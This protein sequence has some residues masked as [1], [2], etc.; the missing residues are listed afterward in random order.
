MGP[1]VLQAAVGRCALFPCRYR[2]C[3]AAPPGVR[4]TLRWL[5]DPIFSRPYGDFRGPLLASSDPRSATRGRLVAPPGGAEGDCSMA[6]PAVTVEDAGNYGMRL[7]ANATRRQPDWRWLYNVRLNVSGTWR[8][9]GGATHNYNP[10][11]DPTTPQ[12]HP[13]QDPTIAQ[14]HPNQDP[15]TPQLYPNYTPTRTQPQH[16]YTPTRTQL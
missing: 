10:N 12:L 4:P 5:R 6:L 15:I 7:L 1:S 11:Q 16:N 13:N 3:P 14:L 2:L 8:S 9:G